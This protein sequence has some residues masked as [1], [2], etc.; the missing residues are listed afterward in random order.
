MR[1][2]DY[3]GWL[4]TDNSASLAQPENSA[5]NLV[6]QSYTITAPTFQL[7]VA[8]SPLCPER[9]RLLLPRAAP[10]HGWV[11]PCSKSCGTTQHSIPFAL[12]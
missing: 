8:S 6:R 12:A 3:A 7:T 2:G 10:G 1:W 4:Q 9:R 5:P 11:G